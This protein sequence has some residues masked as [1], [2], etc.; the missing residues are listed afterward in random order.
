MQHTLLRFDPAQILDVLEITT[1]MVTEKNT[2]G[3]RLARL[4]ITTY[5]SNS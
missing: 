3:A 4:R 2:L 1:K 5:F